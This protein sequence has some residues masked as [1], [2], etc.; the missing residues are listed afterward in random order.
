MRPIPKEAKDLT[1]AVLRDPDLHYRSCWE[2][3]SGRPEYDCKC[4]LKDVI[5]KIILAKEV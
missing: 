1:L 2:D 3:I 4:P 5:D